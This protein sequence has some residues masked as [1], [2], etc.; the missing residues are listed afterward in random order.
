MW[1][2]L[3]CLTLLGL[4]GCSSIWHYAQPEQ[5]RKL[6]YGPGPRSDFEFSQRD[7]MRASEP[8]ILRA[9][10]PDR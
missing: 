3:A 5:W 2:I 4:C 6:N 8:M 7:P 1:R 10:N 9:Q